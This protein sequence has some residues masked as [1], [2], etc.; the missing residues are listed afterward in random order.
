MNVLLW[1]LPCDSIRAEMHLV[2]TS[3]ASRLCLSDWIQSQ[4]YALAH[5]LLDAQCLIGLSIF[6]P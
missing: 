5:A 2:G 3:T 1:V 6:S 4:L